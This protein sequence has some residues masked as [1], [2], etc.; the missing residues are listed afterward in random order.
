MNGCNVLYAETRCT[1][2]EAHHAC[3]VYKKNE[4]LLLASCAGASVHA[5]GLRPVF[6]ELHS[7]A[8]AQ[9]GKA[10][11]A[12]DFDASVT[13]VRLAEVEHGSFELRPAGA[14][15]IES[16]K[17]N[18][19]TSLPSMSGHEMVG[20]VV[21]VRPH[22]ESYKDGEVVGGEWHGGHCFN[23]A[24]QGSSLGALSN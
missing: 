22:E 16:S 17:F 19:P 14:E 11:E 7:M 21:A 10:S 8:C 20:E 4:I 1:E 6:P 12:P 18:F 13:W 9:R 5:A 2:A 15:R 24:Q 3:G 23:C